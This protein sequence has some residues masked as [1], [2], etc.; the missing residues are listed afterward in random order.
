VR[1]RKLSLTGD[2]ETVRRGSVQAVLELATELVTEERG[3]PTR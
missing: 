3:A 1:V 2:R